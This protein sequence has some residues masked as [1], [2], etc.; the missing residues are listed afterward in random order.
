MRADGAQ[1]AATT[2]DSKLLTW[3]PDGKAALNVAAT[4]PIHS[5]RYGAADQFLAAGSADNLVRLFSSKDGRVLEEIGP[6]GPAP[7]VPVT[8]LSV[9]VDG[10]TFLT[11]GNANAGSIVR[12]S[13]VAKVDAHEGGANAVTFTADGTLLTTG[14]E[15]KAA[16]LWSIPADAPIEPEKVQLNGFAGATASITGVDVTADGAVLAASSA[17][18]SVY[19]WPL[20]KAP[21]AE[22]IAATG[23]F[24]LGSPVRSISLAADGTRIAACADDKL[25]RVWDVVSGRELQRFPGHEAAVLAVD[26]A[27]DQKTLVSASADK[28]VRL[29]NVAATRVIEADAAAINDLAVRVVGEATTIATAGAD[30]TVRLWSV[31]GAAAGQLAGPAAEVAS[32]A[33]RPDGK[34]IVATSALAVFVWDLPAAL[35]ATPLPVT[36]QFVTTAAAHRAQYQADGTQFAVGTANGRLQ[37]HAAAGGHL[38]EVITQAAPVT[39]LAFAPDKRTLL[40]PGVDNSATAYRMSFVKLLAGHEGAVTSVAFI[41]GGASIFTAGVDKTVRQWK[42]DD[43]TQIATFAGLTD[44]ALGLSLSTDGKKLFAAGADKTVLAWDVPAAAVTE[45]VAA[46]ATLTN[47]EAVLNVSANA[48]GSRVA[49]TGADGIVRIWDV[50]TGRE[51]ER[52]VAVLPFEFAVT[53]PKPPQENCNDRPNDRG[54]PQNVRNDATVL[55]DTAEGLELTR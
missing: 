35:P 34:Q 12:R 24:T 41:P 31:E 53:R 13:L 49:A 39:A 3:T 30:K 23:T 32:V 29:W 9:A 20:T 47:P 44:A 2:A 14:G 6:V 42:L 28:S 38:L 21:A 45:A 19:T 5:L 33:V 52:F 26:F 17:D 37:L 1:I 18:G 25:V 16:R 10:R 11:N 54:Q 50:A 8:S 22:P 40:V 46:V 4:S 51:L 55:G 15:D 27:V 48:D 43:G 7:A 36:A